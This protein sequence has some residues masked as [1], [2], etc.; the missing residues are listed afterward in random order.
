M[1]LAATENFFDDSRGWVDS[2]L[3]FANI[4]SNPDDFYCHSPLIVRQS[5]EPALLKSEP[6][7]FWFNGQNECATAAPMEQ[8]QQGFFESAGNFSNTTIPTVNSLDSDF[9]DTDALLDCS[10]GFMNQ[11]PDSPLTFFGDHQDPGHFTTTIVEQHQQQQMTDGVVPAS[12]PANQKR[13]HLPPSRS[14]EP[15][16]KSR[17]RK[18]DAKELPHLTEDDAAS[19]SSNKKRVYRK[20][21]Y[22]KKSNCNR[23]CQS[24]HISNN[25]AFIP[26][27]LR[28]KSDIMAYVEEVFKHMDESFTLKSATYQ[29]HLKKFLPDPKN[30]QRKYIQTILNFPCIPASESEKDEL[31]LLRDLEVGAS[32]SSVLES[33]TVKGRLD[34]L[35]TS[36]VNKVGGVKRLFKRVAR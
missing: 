3:P 35:L 1:N 31:T 26:A 33:I 10:F 17:Q 5:V 13:R 20:K 18:G 15:V 24:G 19:K 2:L 11:E 4:S 30:T 27:E 32:P 22:E 16:V 29:L 9:L 23:N 36:L 25:S 28:S 34:E 12:F 6:P 21:I 7:T 8:Q 14:K